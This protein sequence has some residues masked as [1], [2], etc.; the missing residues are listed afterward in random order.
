MGSVVNTVGFYTAVFAGHGEV[1]FDEGS[2]AAQDQS[3]R[4]VV[5]GFGFGFVRSWP[6]DE[7]APVPPIFKSHSSPC[8]STIGAAETFPTF[9]SMLDCF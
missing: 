9:V 7:E 5:V 1:V 3:E 8:L 4:V 6:V 2:F